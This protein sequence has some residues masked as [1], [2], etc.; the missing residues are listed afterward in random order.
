MASVSFTRIVT[1]PEPVTDAALR[2]VRQD[3]TDAFGQIAVK[4][5][6]GTIWA[7]SRFKKATG[8][9]TR[10][11]VYKVE[12]GA[13]ALIIYN[14]AVNRYGTNY[15]KFVHLA[16]RPRA[17]RLMLEVEKY[18]QLD[19]AKRIGRALAYAGIKARKEG[20]LVT[21]TEVISG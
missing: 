6:Q 9:S 16:G 10:A 21:T 2:K 8:K 12:A 11:W 5:I 17:D 18:A 13:K 20:R 3:V 19:L 1:K 7:M 4:E 14:L 15:P